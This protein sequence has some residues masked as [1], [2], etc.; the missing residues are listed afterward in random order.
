MTEDIVIVREIVSILEYYKLLN[1]NEEKYVDAL[2]NCRNYLK[3]H[4][5]HQF[6]SDFIDIDPDRTQFV[7]YCSDCYVTF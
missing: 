1:P 5:S 7:R 3:K 6:V 4:C 2:N